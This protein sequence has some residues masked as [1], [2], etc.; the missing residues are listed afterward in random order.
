M[1]PGFEGCGPAAC[2]LRVGPC[3][4]SLRG[5]CVGGVGAQVRSAYVGRQRGAR[6]LL[7]TVGFR[8]GTFKRTLGGWI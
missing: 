1:L 3:A 2:R 7:V 4:H 5:M 8:G 6:L